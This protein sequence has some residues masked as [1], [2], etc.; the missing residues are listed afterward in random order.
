MVGLHE[1]SI[2]TSLCVNLL[3]FAGDLGGDDA[4]MTRGASPHWHPMKTP[5]IGSETGHAPD[6]EAI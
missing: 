2:G 5:K 4:L 3:M 6:Y 1:I